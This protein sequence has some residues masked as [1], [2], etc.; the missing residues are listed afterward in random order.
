MVL[1]GPVDGN[2]LSPRAHLVIEGQ[3]YLNTISSALSLFPPVMLGPCDAFST[4]LDVMAHL[5]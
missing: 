3:E 1:D 4:R 2:D 5:L